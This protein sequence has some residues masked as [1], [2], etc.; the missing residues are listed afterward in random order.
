MPDNTGMLA[1]RA[2]WGAKPLW[3]ATG[4]YEAVLA[5]VIA[6]AVIVAVTFSLAAIQNY[7]L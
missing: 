5:G 7:I 2:R 3:A 6:A 4:S 1:S